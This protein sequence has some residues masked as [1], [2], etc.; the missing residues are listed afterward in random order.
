[1]E[2]PLLLA[3]TA[4]STPHTTQSVIKTHSVNVVIDGPQLTQL[5]DVALALAPIAQ[6]V[7]LRKRG[8][9]RPVL[10]IT[11]CLAVGMTAA[12]TA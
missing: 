9:R 8:D 10:D 2:R 5:G 3:A 1:M 6:A 7:T 12:V 11:S 4:L